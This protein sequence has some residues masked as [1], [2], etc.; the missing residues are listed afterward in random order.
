MLPAVSLLNGD[1]G[2]RA[3]G[4]PAHPLGSM[5]VTSIGSFGLDEVYVAPMPL[6]RVPFYVCVGAVN[7]AALAVDGQVVVRPQPV[8]WAGQAFSRRSLACSSEWTVARSGSWIGSG[9]WGRV[10][11]PAATAANAPASSASSC[12]SASRW[13]ATLSVAAGP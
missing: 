4:Q 5:F 2:V 13:A 1:I 9:S 8:R 12:R 11:A 7:D 3:L 10:S 6:A